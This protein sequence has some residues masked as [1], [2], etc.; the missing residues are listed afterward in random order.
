MDSSSDT[1]VITGPH[2]HIGSMLVSTTQIVPPQVK[3]GGGGGKIWARQV[4]TPESP[5]D[6]VSLGQA[7]GGEMRG[8]KGTSWLK[9]LSGI[10]ST[11]Q[12]E[13]EERREPGKVENPK[14][15]KKASWRGQAQ[16]DNMAS[17]KGDREQRGEKA[18]SRVGREKRARGRGKV[19]EVREERGGK[20]EV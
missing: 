13:G 9:R 14:G 3:W 16:R 20:R 5:G 6:G 2:A 4:C 11:V 18:K 1:S 15:R 19:G 7:Q 8:W 10:R 12:G 17:E